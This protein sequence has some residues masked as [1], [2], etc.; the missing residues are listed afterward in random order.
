M[1][2]QAKTLGVNAREKEI[3]KEHRNAPN[4]LFVDLELYQ[5]P[6]D[7][8]LRQSHL[9]IIR[10]GIDIAANIL[11]DFYLTIILLQFSI[12]FAAILCNTL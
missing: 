11:R 5:N 9:Q 12:F 1:R 4:F 7:C 8:K 3:R 6:F 10:I 2:S